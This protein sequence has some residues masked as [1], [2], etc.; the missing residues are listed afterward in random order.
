MSVLGWPFAASSFLSPSRKNGSGACKISDKNRVIGCPHQSYFYF[1]EAYKILLLTDYHKRSCCESFY[2]RG[3]G[4]Y[5]SGACRK[6][7]SSSFSVSKP[8]WA[9][10]FCTTLI[11][12][13]GAHCKAPSIVLPF[14]S[15]A[16][17]VE[18]KES[19]APVRSTGGAG[20]GYK[21]IW[22]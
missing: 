18:A 4:L 22:K 19:P 17:N 12:L 13:I 1:A 21:G 8:A 5:Q 2:F 16:T 9:P 6:K 7:C 11:E 3:V 10:T 14:M 20:S 15:A